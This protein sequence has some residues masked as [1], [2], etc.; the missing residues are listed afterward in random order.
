MT[1]SNLCHGKFATVEKSYETFLTFDAAFNEMNDLIFK[2]ISGRRDAL[3]RL[4][5]GM[6]GRRRVNFV[7]A[8]TKPFPPQLKPLKRY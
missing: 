4:A 5:V 3:Q 8:V 1:A 7:A 6:T 2:L